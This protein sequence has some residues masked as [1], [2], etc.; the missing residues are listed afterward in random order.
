MYFHRFYRLV[1][2]VTI[3]SAFSAT[4]Y[5]FTGSGPLWPYQANF[6]EEKCQQYWWTNV[7]FINNLY[8]WELKDECVGWLWYLANDMQFF[9]LMPIFLFLYRRNRVLGYVGVFVTLLL[10]IVYCIAITYAQDVNISPIL[11][12]DANYFIIN[13]YTDYLYVRPWARIGAYMV[14]LLFGFMYFEFRNRDRYQQL[15]Y[16]FGARFFSRVD[17]AHG[18]RRVLFFL[19][20]ALTF[21]IVFS[22]H[23]AYKCMGKCWNTSQ[24]A[25][26][27]GLSRVLFVLG[28]ALA[29][30][31]ALVGHNSF[32][33]TLLGGDVW[34]VFSRLNYSV[35][36]IH[37]YVFYWYYYTSRQA[38]TIQASYIM[39]AYFA[40]VI[41]AYVFAFP[42]TLICEAPFLQL[43]KLVL[44]APRQVGTAYTFVSQEL[45]PR[46]SNRPADTAG[47]KL[48]G[49]G[50]VSS[51][52][53]PPTKLYY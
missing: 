45:D 35:Y 12:T 47:E 33:Q 30:S 32:L 27:N 15:K 50:A 23:D 9:L 13:K 21:V 4:L 28:M 16:S 29:T 43:E 49:N 53:V 2:P 17:R 34:E 26:Y 5:R 1:F 20:F 46:Y 11:E 22:Q 14:G 51:S 48:L 18:F 37:M 42:F 7:L 19:G 41:V 44:F 3:L 31:G 52:T 10:N 36:M 6:T 25:F 24:N 40:C 38:L 8:P 39:W